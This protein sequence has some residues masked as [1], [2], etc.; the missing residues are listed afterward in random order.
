MTVP[1]APGR[2][3][4]HWALFAD[5]CAAN[6]RCGLPASP[7]TIAAFL[8]ELP[9]GPV[10]V[11]RRVRAIDAAHRAAGLAAPGASPELDALLGRTRPG[12]RFETDLLAKALANITIGGWP[13]GIV[14][15]RDAAV[16]ALICAAGLTRSQVQALRIEVR[17]DLPLGS[18]I[19]VG[20]AAGER[21]WPADLL[22]AMPKAEAAGDCPACA[23]ARWLDV[24]SRLARS[25]WR[26]VR[27]ELADYGEVAAGEETTHSC[28]H[29]LG[30]APAGG[31]GGVPLFCAIDRHGAPETGWAIST[32]SLTAI[33]A[34]R[35]A[36]AEQ[37]D[38]KEAVPEAAL[39][40]SPPAGVSD[41]EWGMAQRRVAEERFAQIEATLDEAEA[42]AE[43]IL[44]RVH[45]AMGNDEAQLR[46]AR[47]CS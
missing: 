7:V 12:P 42:E 22:A 47:W 34:G 38:A 19:S 9:A 21:G 15:R 1:A 26:A 40:S 35:L 23:L 36:T 14:G 32:R 43:A 4:R 16:V 30:G 6:A 18:R 28:G 39:R 45:A 13:A 3:D 27:A 31:G 10:T 11:A 44:A 20:T 5:W 41:H 17:E 33:V 29:A 24:A 8:T 2:R 37:G 25:G 46:Q